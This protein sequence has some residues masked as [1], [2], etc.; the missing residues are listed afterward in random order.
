[1]QTNG[2][3]ALAMAAAL[4]M[5]G[6]AAAIA[7]PQRLPWSHTY[8]A[9]VTVAAI[10]AVSRR[11]GTEYQSAR[12]SDEAHFDNDTGGA[13]A[14]HLGNPRLNDAYAFPANSYFADA[15]ARIDPVAATM[16]LASDEIYVG[17]TFDSP[18]PAKSWARQV[19][20]YGSAQA[21]LEDTLL[22]VNP[23]P[24]TYAYYEINF[25]GTF[26]SMG[27]TAY[28]T[29]DIKF[30]FEWPTGTVPF[31]LSYRM[32][33]TAVGP[34]ALTCSKYLQC[35]GAT[36]TGS[37]FA[38]FR[39]PYMYLHFRERSY[40]YD[41]TIATGIA[42]RAIDWAGPMPTEIHSSSGLFRGTVAGI[43]EP[44]GWALMIA[45]FGVA[46]VRLRS[47]RVSAG[48]ASLI[49]AAASGGAS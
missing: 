42:L 37:L 23:H 20:T 27:S 33:A 10:A 36:L 21:T 31:M 49:S 9:A 25:S 26:A 48:C 44:A 2:I 19:L 16:D 47:R 12:R 38:G 28:L 1:M 45:G 11:D 43:P 17:E 46:G 35:D 6:S 7:P 15:S 40:A 4:S 13:V 5:A 41:G 24:G 8:Q 29:S 39:E 34:D 22:F 18:I 3:R 32:T 14:R 30:D